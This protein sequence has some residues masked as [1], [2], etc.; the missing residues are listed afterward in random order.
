MPILGILRLTHHGVT[1]LWDLRFPVPRAGE[2]SEPTAL[3]LDGSGGGGG[4]GLRSSGLQG[5]LGLRGFKGFLESIGFMGFKGFIGFIGL[6]FRL[7][8]RL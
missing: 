6:F 1:A 4:W 3:K 2:W 5:L 7:K 8:G